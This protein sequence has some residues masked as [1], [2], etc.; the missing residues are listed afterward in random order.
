MDH[1]ENVSSITACFLVARE[2][3]YPQSFCLAIAVVLSPVYRAVTQLW[4]YMSYCSLLK[5]P[6]PS[7]SFLRGWNCD[8]YINPGG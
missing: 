3:M 2:T 7:T 5:A 6:H 1:T 4:V 8:M